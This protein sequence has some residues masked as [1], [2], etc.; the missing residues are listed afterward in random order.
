M[1]RFHHFGLAWA[2]ATLWT[3]AMGGWATLAQETPPA[4]TEREEGVEVLTRG[5]IHEAF[6]EP[7]TEPEPT[8]VVEKAPPEE[9]EEVPPEYAPEEE[10]VEWIPGYWAWDDEREDFIWIS[11]VYRVPPPDMRWVA[12]YWAE[13]DGGWQWNPGFWTAVESQ[14]LVYYQTPPASLEEGPSSPSP[15]EDHFWVPGN[16]VYQDTDFRWTPGYWALHRPD[17]IWVPARWVWTPRGCI[18]L[19]GRWD[20]IFERRGFCYAP[21]Y[22]QPAIYRRPGYVYRPWC[23]LNVA[24]L[25]VHFWIR[26]NY[27]HYYFGNYYGIDDRWGMSPWSS[28]YGR[29]GYYDPIL[30]WCQVHY[31][32]RGI[33][34]VDRIS[35]WHTYYERHQD[36]RPPRTWAEQTRLISQSN[37]NNITEINQITNVAVK[38]NFLAGRVPDLARMENAP[39]RLQRLDERRQREV[40]QQ[41]KEISREV[42]EIRQQRRESERS[43]ARTEGRSPVAGEKNGTGRAAGETRGRLKLPESRVAARQPRVEVPERPDGDRPGAGGRPDR[44]ARA[45]GERP[46]RPGEKADRPERPERPGEKSDRPDTKGERPERPG[47]KG[48]RPGVKGERPERP[49]EKSDRA[50]APQRPDRTEAPERPDRTAP[51]GRTKS[52]ERPEPRGKAD[53][54]EPPGRSERSGEP[55]G[56]RTD[57]PGIEPPPRLPSRDDRPGADGDERPGPR[58]ELPEGGRSERSARSLPSGGR[59]DIRGTPAGRPRSE[60][61]RPEVPDE[62]T[63]PRPRQDRSSLEPKGRGP[64]TRPSAERPRPESGA[65]RAG[66]RSER[67]RPEAQPDRPR[68]SSGPGKSSSKSRAEREKEKEKEKEKDRDEK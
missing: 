56:P 35:L 3:I 32:R 54:P 63:G 51:P 33:D 25:F 1:R 16:W 8:I 9:I 48:D 46:D 55:R 31:Q 24:N 38:Q 13:A 52:P 12:G 50:K 18:Y 19:P 7:L 66:P 4:P 14:E 11:G 5:P 43:V 59:P 42:K 47:S 40:A 17:W 58:V 62:R 65:D 53:R 44:S 15:G 28:W 49:G 10:G 64:E 6:A 41:A 29:R 20:Y 23:G 26:P 45:P 36:V 60:A 67:P 61:L 22:F 21:T 57:R 39:I 37:I 30:N 68:P 2:A 27:C 34:F